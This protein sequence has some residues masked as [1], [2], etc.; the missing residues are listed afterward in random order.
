MNW[1]TINAIGINILLIP[2]LHG[3]QELKI[4]VESLPV[5]IRNRGYTPLHLAAYFGHIEKIAQLIATNADVCASSVNG[6][7]P[8]H[9]AAERGN[10]GAVEALITE[11]KKMSLVNQTTDT[12]SIVDIENTEGASPLACAAANG[13][14][15]CLTCLIDHG[16]SIWVEDNRGRFP[17]HRA[18]RNGHLD[19]MKIL[20]PDDHCVLSESFWLKANRDAVE[21]GKIEVLDYVRQRMPGGTRGYQIDSGIENVTPLLGIAASFGHVSLMQWYLAQAGS[22][23]SERDE[24]GDTALHYAARYGQAEAAEFLLQRDPT[25]IDR[26]GGQVRIWLSGCTAL[27]EAAAAGH[28]NVIE[29]LLRHNAKI[30][31]RTTSG[32][33]SLHLS[34][35]K[36]HTKAVELL[37]RAGAS[38]EAAMANGRTPLHEAA[39]NGQRG[40]VEAL[41]QHNAPIEATDSTNCTPLLCAIE[42]G[43]LAVIKCLLSHG[44]NI[45]HCSRIGNGLIHAFKG[46]ER[47]KLDV[48]HYLLHNT[49]IDLRCF[50]GNFLS[51]VPVLFDAVYR[52]KSKIVRLLITEGSALDTQLE[53][54]RTIL[55]CAAF[56]KG[57]KTNG[58]VKLLVRAGANMLSPDNT[59][60]TPLS[61]LRSKPTQLPLDQNHFHYFQNRSLYLS[62][63]LAAGDTLD[64]VSCIAAEFL[65]IPVLEAFRDQLG[66]RLM[67]WRKNGK[68]LLMV[69]ITIDDFDGIKWLL[70]QKICN[71]TDFDAENHDALWLAVSNTSDSARLAVVNMLLADGATVTEEHLLQ[72]AKSWNENS[73]NEVLMRLVTIYRYSQRPQEERQNLFK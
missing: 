71:I 19:A 14:I 22:D 43:H 7:T 24:Q 69:A 36:G 51:I 49:E 58:M 57:R 17:F 53:D 54:G 1:Q 34:A 66:D 56:D 38:P 50:S 32:A 35:K 2:A 30:D 5:E 47:N 20:L 25:L 73:V 63:R 67:K 9:L 10:V 13:H 68:N 60:D 55:H 15:D 42:G 70:D 64:A 29:V 59:G 3:M 11:F 37:L 16:A 18:A 41:L 21:S 27:H 31:A 33:T 48:I 52:R 28:S 23:I 45:K 62:G 26:E 46:T 8:L 39:Q 6:S 12:P 65:D 4:T 61:K 40:C 44:A 72:A